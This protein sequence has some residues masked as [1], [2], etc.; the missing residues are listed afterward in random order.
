MLR[1]AQ[2]GGG[3]TRT[4]GR[5][6]RV[7]G[8]WGKVD[9]AKVANLGRASEEVWGILLPFTTTSSTCLATRMTMWTMSGLCGLCR[10]PG[11]VG[12]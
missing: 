9:L 6:P 2:G 1:V 10:T 12:L 4:P 11:P 7:Q 3:L 5:R 8:G